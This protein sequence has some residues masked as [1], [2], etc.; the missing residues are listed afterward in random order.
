MMEASREPWR[1]EGLFLRLAKLGRGL[2]LANPR[3]ARSYENYFK[4]CNFF[5]SSGLK[6]YR[7]AHFGSARRFLSRTSRPLRE[8][9]VYNRNP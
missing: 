3:Q 4:S 9:S 8:E 5:F 7:P 1:K 6:P 2:A